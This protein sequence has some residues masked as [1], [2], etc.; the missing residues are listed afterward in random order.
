MRP[1]C[2]LRTTGV[3]ALPPVSWEWHVAGAIQTFEGE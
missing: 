1:S 2:A 3:A